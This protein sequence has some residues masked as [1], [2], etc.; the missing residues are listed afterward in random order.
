MAMPFEFEHL[1]GWLIKKHSTERKI[2]FGRSTESRRWFKVTEVNGADATEL[3]LGYYASQKVKEAKGFIYL[4]ITR[5]SAKR[6]H[7]FPKR[8]KPNVIIFAF[9]NK[10][11]DNLLKGVEVGISDDL[12]WLRCDLKSISLLPNLL[13]KQKARI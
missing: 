13:E 10:N 8:V 11:L 9:S 6:N 4:Q 7:L 5:G 12:R 3:I 1:E 2:N